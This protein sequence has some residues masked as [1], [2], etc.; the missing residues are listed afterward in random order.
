MIP[1]ASAAAYHA[2][3]QA[4][5]SSIAPTAAGSSSPGRTGRTYLQGLLTN[6]IVALRAGQGCYAAYLTPQGRMIADCGLRARRPDPAVARPRREGRRP[7][8]SSISSSSPRT[9]SSATSARRFAAGR[10]WARRRARGIGGAHGVSE[11]AVDA[12]ARSRQPAA[13]FAG[14]ARDRPAHGRYRRAGYELLV[15]VAQAGSLRTALRAAGAV[16]IDADTARRFGSKAACR[17]FIATWTKRRFR[18]K[19][20]SSRAPSA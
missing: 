8:R 7:R 3:R 20:A 10:R 15:D 2:A 12:L 19:R 18:S 11:A 4:P 14:G 16:A 13:Q 1:E 9:C 17:S 5:G 6:D